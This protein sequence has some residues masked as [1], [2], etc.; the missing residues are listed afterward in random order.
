VNSP[1]EYNPGCIAA[2]LTGG[3]H[4]GESIM[5]FANGSIEPPHQLSYHGYSGDVPGWHIYEFAGLAT[6]AEWPSEDTAVPYPYVGFRPSFQ[7][8]ESAMLLKDAEEALEYV[9][10]HTSH[11]LVRAKA[12][13]ALTLIRSGKKTQ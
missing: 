9:M 13:A 3:P 11:T 7:I 2:N 4:D 12:Q 8:D 5:L 10:T 6:L 1:T